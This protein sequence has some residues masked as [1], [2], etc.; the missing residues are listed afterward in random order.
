[1]TKLIPDGFQYAGRKYELK[2]GYREGVY[3]SKVRCIVSPMG[4][5]IGLSTA[6]NHGIAVEVWE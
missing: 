3:P 6:V 1:L 4:E 2:P 5:R